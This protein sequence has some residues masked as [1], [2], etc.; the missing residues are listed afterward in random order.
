MPEKQFVEKSRPL[1]STYKQDFMPAQVKTQLF[2]E[3]PKTSFEGVPTTSYRYA[4]GTG[5]PNKATINAMNNEALR[6]SL[7]N[8]KD[9]A[10]SA[11]HRGRE[12]VA[13]CL[14][15]VGPKQKCSST[16]ESIRPVVPLATQTTE[17]VPHP[18]SAPKPE[19][20]TASPT[21]VVQEAWPVPSAPPTQNVA[22]PTQQA[23]V[24]QEVHVPPPQPMAE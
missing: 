14:T 16:Q 4:H 12:T 22:P 21:Q 8:R 9:R 13:S 19:A 15:W 1:S 23:P 7:L 24:T 20:T 3:R 5:A 17:F 10:M 18:P 11:V 6:L 2:I